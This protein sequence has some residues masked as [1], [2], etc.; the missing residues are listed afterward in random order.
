MKT[1]SDKTKGFDR[2]IQKPFDELPESFMRN[3]RSRW[4]TKKMKREEQAGDT[5][6][7]ESATSHGSSPRDTIY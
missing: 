7:L 6:G 1:N 4:V 3:L 5:S 2:P